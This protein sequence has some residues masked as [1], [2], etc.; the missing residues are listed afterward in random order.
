MSVSLL[1]SHLSVDDTVSSPPNLC[2][3]V[4]FNIVIMPAKSHFLGLSKGMYD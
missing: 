2:V 4:K 1:H 3:V